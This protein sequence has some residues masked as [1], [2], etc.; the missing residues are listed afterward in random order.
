MVQGKQKTVTWGTFWIS[1]LYIKIKNICARRARNARFDKNILLRVCMHVRLTRTRGR[2]AR[3]SISC[4]IFS[5]NALF[6]KVNG[7]HKVQLMRR[8]TET[9]F[10]TCKLKWRK[11]IFL[12]QIA[13][14]DF[15]EATYFQ[16][17]FGLI[18]KPSFVTILE[19]LK[20]LVKSY[21]KLHFLFPIQTRRRRIGTKYF[22]LFSF[23]CNNTSPSARVNLSAF[24]E[25]ATNF[26]LKKIMCNNSYVKIF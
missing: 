1:H 18:S 19:W 10:M 8:I 23:H 11:S 21:R 5:P 26:P 13:E 9:F 2:Y 15:W 20:I 25:N 22:Q 3:T 4:T 16:D 12:V 7:F 6:N 14:L 24:W 17:N